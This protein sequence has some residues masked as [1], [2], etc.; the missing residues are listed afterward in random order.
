MSEKYRELKS[1]PFCGGNL[2]IPNLKTWP[3]IWPDGEN[4]KPFWEIHCLECGAGFNDI[5][6]TEED[7]VNRWNTRR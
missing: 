3:E 6:E 7:A 2:I 1:C 4:Y 5:F